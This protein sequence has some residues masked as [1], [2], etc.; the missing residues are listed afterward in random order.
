MV[1]GETGFLESTTYQN[2]RIDIK[3]DI[4]S[5]DI[6]DKHLSDKAIIILWAY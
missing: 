2:L 5:A 1:M 6:A 3:L 4:L